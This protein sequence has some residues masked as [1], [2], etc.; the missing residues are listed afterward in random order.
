MGLRMDMQ[1]AL[2]GDLV[3]SSKLS[4]TTKWRYSRGRFPKAVIWFLEHPEM[5]RAALSAYNAEIK[6][7]ALN[8]PVVNTAVVSE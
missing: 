3:A 6:P 2:N 8:A 7:D 1:K 5:F 4:H